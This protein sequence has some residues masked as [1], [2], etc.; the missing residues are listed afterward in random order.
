[1][2]PSSRPRPLAAAGLVMMTSFFVRSANH[3]C[4]CQDEGFIKHGERCVIMGCPLKYALSTESRNLARPTKPLRIILFALLPALSIIFRTITK[5]ARLSPWGFDDLFVSLAYFL[6]LA[7][8]S[9]AFYLTYLFDVVRSTELAIMLFFKV[10]LPSYA[11]AAG[12]VSKFSSFSF[13]LPSQL[14]FHRDS[15]PYK[16]YI[17]P[18]YTRSKNLSSSRTFGYLIFAMKNSASRCGLTWQ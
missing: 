14:T 13:S 9:L 18:A 11:P 10:T 6:L 4:L 8:T 3:T 7:Y 5:F 15:T 12:A 16:N 17:T 2:E 1:M